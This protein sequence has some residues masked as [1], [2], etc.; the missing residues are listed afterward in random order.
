MSLKFT[1]F[2]FLGV[3]L[4]VT[5]LAGCAGTTGGDKILAHEVTGTGPDKVIVLHD[6]LGDRRN[7]DDARPYLDMQSFTFAFA[8]LR[9]YGGSVKMKG[10]FTSD[11]AAGDV[12]RLSKKHSVRFL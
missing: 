8:D 7:Y 3:M 5:T 10:M 6:W 2:R 9:G 11:E 1:I 4:T 12:L